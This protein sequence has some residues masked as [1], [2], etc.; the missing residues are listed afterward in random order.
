MNQRH[1][2]VKLSLTILYILFVVS[3]QKYQLSAMIGFAVYPLFMFSLAD[4]SLKDAL[5]RMRLILMLVLAVVFFIYAVS[6]PEGS[7]PWSNWITYL[8]YGIYLA[9]TVLFAGL[10]IAGTALLFVVGGG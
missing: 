2:L 6:H 5:H 10:A 9:V 3:C 8:I 1:P 7:F 4:L